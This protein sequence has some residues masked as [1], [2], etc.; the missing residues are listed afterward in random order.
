MNK[1]NEKDYEQFSTSLPIKFIK[2]L[3][4]H[5]FKNETSLSQMLVNYQNSHIENLECEKT[6]KKLKKELVEHGKV[7]CPWCG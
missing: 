3:R 2:L 6:E 4:L 5:A 1:K 7:K